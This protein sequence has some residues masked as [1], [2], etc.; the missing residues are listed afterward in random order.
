[1]KDE[2][3]NVS[4]PAFT[5][6]FRLHPSSFQTKPCPYKHHKGSSVALGRLSRRQ[7]HPKLAKKLKNPG[8][9]QSQS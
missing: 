6:S 1:M 8:T 4:A 5:S 3:A 7:P 2:S 9:F